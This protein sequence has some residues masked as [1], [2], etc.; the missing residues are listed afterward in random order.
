MRKLA[1]R[2][3]HEGLFSPEGLADGGRLLVTEG[4]TDCGAPLDLGFHAVG[5]PS[6]TGGVKLLVELVG[7]QRPAEAII[8][9]DGDGPGQ[10]GAETLAVVLVA[11]AAAVR[12]L[13]LRP[14]S[15]TPDSGS[16]G[17]QRRPT[18]WRRSTRRRSG[19]WRSR[20]GER[21]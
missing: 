2:G 4:P 3:G 13:H 5:R 8:V 20:S 11:Y 19:G 15:K 17:E 21:G 6:C 9:G 12:V 14:A 1:V 18:C 10:R 7:Q 16:D